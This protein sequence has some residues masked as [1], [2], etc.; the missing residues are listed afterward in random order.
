MQIKF[1]HKKAELRVPYPM[2]NNMPYTHNKI[3]ANQVWI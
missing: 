1:Q 3:N 2:I